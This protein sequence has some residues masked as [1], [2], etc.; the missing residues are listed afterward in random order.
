M[1]MKKILL[2]ILMLFLLYS[3]A[4][5]VGA[6]TFTIDQI[7]PANQPRRVIITLS[8][9]ADAIAA[10]VPSTTIQ[11]ALIKGFYLY[12]A[13]TNPG[14]AVAPTDNY[15]IVINDADGLDIAG[16]LLLNRDTANT[17]IINIGTSGHG[18]PIVRGDLTFVLSN[19]AVN[20]ATGTCILVFVAN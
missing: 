19:N 12:S 10:T 3:S 1:K 14:N 17:E 13:E 5:A 9:T 11:G 15:D 18:Y 7:E 6:V 20:S 2:T 8:W 4:F 16:S